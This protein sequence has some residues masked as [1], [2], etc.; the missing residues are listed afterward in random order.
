MDISADQKLL[1]PGF[2]LTD[3]ICCLRRAGAF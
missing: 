1:L 2:G 3:K